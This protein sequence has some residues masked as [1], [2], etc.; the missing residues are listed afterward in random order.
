MLVR[1]LQVLAAFVRTS[2]RGAASEATHGRRGAVDGTV[3]AWLGDAAA[4]LVDYDAALGASELTVQRQR[5]AVNDV[6]RKRD[7]VLLVVR[8]MVPPVLDLI[9]LQRSSC[10]CY[11]RKLRHVSQMSTT[12]TAMNCRQILNLFV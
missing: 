11:D 4:R 1:V 10:I 12:D 8:T 9:V 3:R 2:M 7:M 5:I 6:E